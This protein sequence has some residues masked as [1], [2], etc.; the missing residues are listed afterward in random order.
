M[1]TLS[2]PSSSSNASTYTE[3]SSQDVELEGP[4]FSPLLTDDPW[5][6]T[7][8]PLRILSHLHSIRYWRRKIRGFLAGIGPMLKTL[9]RLMAFAGTRR[10]MT[11]I[12]T[13]YHDWPNGE[14]T[15]QR[16]FIAI[17]NEYFIHL[18]EY[19]ALRDEYLLFAGE[20]KETL[21]DP[22][23]E[24][25]GPGD[26]L[27]HILHAQL[28]KVSIDLDKRLVE[29]RD[30]LRFAH[31]A[32]IGFYDYIGL[33]RKRMNG[34]IVVPNP[35]MP[36]DEWAAYT[37]PVWMAELADLQPELENGGW[38]E[39]KY[40][41]LRQNDWRMQVWEAEWLALPEGE[42]QK[43]YGCRGSGWW[44]SEEER[45]GPEADRRRASEVNWQAHHVPSWGT[46]VF[47]AVMSRQSTARI[48]A[49]I[50]TGESKQSIADLLK[51]ARIP[52]DKPTKGR[53]SRAMGWL[54]MTGKR[55]LCETEDE[56]LANLGPV[57]EPTCRSAT[58]NDKF[59]SKRIEN[60]PKLALEYLTGLGTDNWRWRDVVDDSDGDPA[61]AGSQQDRQGS[62]SPDKTVEFLQP[63][64]RRFVLDDSDGS[65]ENPAATNSQQDRRMSDDPEESVAAVL[66]PASSRFTLDDSDGSDDAKTTN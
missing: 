23:F 8:L 26:V 59:K 45:E 1:A 12:K 4:S 24:S 18:F 51:N 34:N 42:R 14:R 30:K 35:L 32:V 63:T 37:E 9:A 27:A 54:P 58:I 29:A 11:T 49:I 47:N 25:Q 7:P 22:R 6:H 33:L 50:G 46:R 65:D 48:G 38:C 20:L 57:L 36:V 13:A 53:T 2:P 64:S 56:F 62:D 3:S 17:K 15:A 40:G 52:Q 55:H 19:I 21:G 44:K 28:V 41:Q 43:L 61:A 5:L 10:V 60:N 31:L 39:E 16:H 66:Q